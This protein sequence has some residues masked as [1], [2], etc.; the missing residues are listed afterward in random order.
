M[1]ITPERAL[2]TGK[3]AVVTGGAQGIGEATAIA[4]AAFGADVAIC[5][6]QADKMPAVVAA[7]EALGRRA[8][9]T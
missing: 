2:L 6:F 5:D 1:E 8:H 7:I 3:V 4:L 9:A